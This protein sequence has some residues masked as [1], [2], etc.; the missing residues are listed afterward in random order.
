MEASRCASYIPVGSEAAESHSTQRYYA[1]P[2]GQPGDCVS[3]LLGL[4]VNASDSQG[5]RCVTFGV[6]LV[7]REQALFSSQRIK[8][9]L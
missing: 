4:G 7:N 3:E 9:K 6:C 2:T 8:E 5:Y 1:D